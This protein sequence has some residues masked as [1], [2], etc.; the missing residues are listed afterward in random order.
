MI[1]GSFAYE[2]GKRMLG[3]IAVVAIVAF[4]FGALVMWAVL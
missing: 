3:C 2:V 1:D 4:A